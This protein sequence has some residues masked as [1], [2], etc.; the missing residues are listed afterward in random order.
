LIID[1]V[2]AI[3]LLYSFEARYSIEFT[4]EE[5][6]NTPIR[7]IQSKNDNNIKKKNKKLYLYC[8]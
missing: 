3:N 6:T 5:I 1:D 8:I 2:K 7:G 4:K